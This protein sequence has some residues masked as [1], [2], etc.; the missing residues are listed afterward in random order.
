MISI[1]YLGFPGKGNTTTKLFSCWF[2]SNLYKRRWKVYFLWE[3]M[4]GSETPTRITPLVGWISTKAQRIKWSWEQI[5]FL[6]EVVVWLDERGFCLR[7]SAPFYLLCEWSGLNP[8][9]QTVDLRS[10]GFLCFLAGRGA[11]P[12]PEAMKD[13]CEQQ[14]RV[15]NRIYRL[16]SQNRSIVFN[17]KN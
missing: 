13:H 2:F 1:I 15:H 10:G 6:W 17:C 5:S 9:S 11:D 8:F 3:K 16:S 7:K 12:V 14:I 4:V